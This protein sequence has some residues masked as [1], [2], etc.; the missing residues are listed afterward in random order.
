MLILKSLS[1]ENF[2]PYKGLQTI[3]FPDQGVS[4]V[5]GEN[6]RG[7]TSLLNAIRYALFG[8]VISRGSTE[9]SLHKIGNWESAKEGDFGFKVVLCFESD[10]QDY[11]LIRQFMPKSGVSEPKD[12]T[13]YTEQFFLRRDGSP[14]GPAE[15]EHELSQI[16]PEQVSRFFLFD[17]E[18]LQEYEELLRDQS[19][20]GDKI[21][22]SIERILGVPV[23]TN[24][25]A[26]V[27]RLFHEAQKNESKVAQL[28]QKTQQI[29]SLHSNAIEQRSA[30]Q[31]ELAR[32]QKQFAELSDQQASIEDELRKTKRIENL[33]NERDR[34][35][36]EIREIQ[37]KREEKKERIKQILSDVWL[38]M[39]DPKIKQLRANLRE[40]VS[41]LRSKEIEVSVTKENLRS[42]RK[43]L[44]DEK[45]P[46]CLRE[47]DQR[48]REHLE[49]I[50]IASTDSQTATIDAELLNEL[51]GRL[52]ALENI[53]TSDKRGTVREILNDLDD[54]SVQESARLDRIEEIKEDTDTYD[55]SEIRRLSSENNGLIRQLTILDGGIKAEKSKVAE[56]SDNIKRMQSQLDKIGGEDFVK[57]RRL[58]ETY[59]KL[60]EL[61][62]EGVSVY[63][64]QLRE[65]VEKDATSLFRKLISEEDYK[66]LEI[67]Q[68]YGLTILHKDG[69]P[70]EVRSAGAEHIVALS[71]MGALQKNAPLSGP[72]IMDSP[73]GRLDDMHT[74]K[75][76]STLPS[77]AGQVMALVYE[78]ELDPMLAREQLRN[79][80][81]EEYQITRRTARH[82]VIEKRVRI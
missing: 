58:R 29:G 66:G 9:V 11:E 75:V 53:E 81:K 7:K 52:T 71:L 39:L 47:L 23:L 55:E 26:D 31:K 13:D 24:T 51:N 15:I 45:C 28:N 40:Q 32:L 18:L 5:Y 27:S 22:Q 3:E 64:D 63:R 67:N 16:M 38:D 34:L 50:I 30:H 69:D 43:A 6:M 65:K 77:M 72:I 59:E 12:N 78:S 14:L 1:L 49:A 56:I 70:I 62:S 76:I 73:F 57:E 19:E 61:M 46:T 4:I 17:G 48:S 8:R 54:M 2:G 36:N 82:S 20:M 80:L 10:G 41:G 35:R 74:T 37:E 44:Q 42:I 21:K 79:N 60:H 33:L 68:N 25:R